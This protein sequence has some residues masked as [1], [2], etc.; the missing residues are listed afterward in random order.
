[1][2]L[3]RLFVG[4]LLLW[5]V[6]CDSPSEPQTGP[7][8][9]LDLLSGN[10]QEATV[11]QPL[12]DPLV[13]R[14]FDENGT[15]LSSQLLNF[16]VISG[17]GSVFAGASLTNSDGVAQE[18]WTLGTSA[19]TQR[20]EV[21]A[22]DNA[23]GE[24]LVFATFVAVAKAGA[25]AAI[26]PVG[27][28]TVT[29][30]AGDAVTDSLVARVTDQYG[31]PVPNIAV[32]WSVTAGSGAVSSA[33]TNTD[34][35]GVARVQWTLGPRV[36]TTQIVTASVM[37]STLATSY[38]ANVTLPANIVVTK[39]SGD[40]QTG[41]VATELMQPLVVSVALADGR[42]VV[43]AG[44]SWSSQVGAVTPQ[45]HTTGADGRA[46]ARWTL[47]TVAGNQTAAASVQGSAPAQFQAL[48]NPAAPAHLIKVS[49][50]AQS[51]NV[52]NALAQPL[53][54]RVRDTY[55]NAVPNALVYWTVVTGNG[56][57]APDSARADANGDSRTVW[58]LGSTSGQ[59]MAR[60]EVAGVA[61]VTFTST[62]HAPIAF[63]VLAP[64]SGSRVSDTVSIAAQTSS[65]LEV[66]S[67]VANVGDRQTNLTFSNGAWRGQIVLT[68]LPRGNYDLLLRATDAAGHSAT[69]D[70]A[71]ILD[72]RPRLT[73][74]LPIN[75]SVARP[76]TRVLASCTDDDPTPC[77]IYIGSAHALCAFTGTS[78]SST[79]IGRGVGTVDLQVSL[80]AWEGQQRTLVIRAADS[81]SQTAHLLQ[82]V[83]VESSSRWTEVASAGIHLFDYD[84]TRL[85]YRDSSA[86]GYS[87]QIRNLQSGITESISDSDKSTAFLTPFGAIFE[88]GNN[89]FERRN[90]SLLDLGSGNELEVAGAWA[91]WHSATASPVQLLRRDLMAGLTEPVASNAGNTNNDVAANGDVVYWDPTYDI[92]RYRSGVTNQLT[93]DNDAVLWNTYPI[94]DGTI[95]VYRKSTP[96][97]TNQTYRLALHDGTTELLLTA[98]RSMQPVPDL[99]YA[100]SEG[101]VAFTDLGP[102]GSL[103]VFSRAPDGTIRQVSQFSSESRVVS[104]GRAGQVIFRNNGRRYLSLPPYANQPVDIG[105]NWGTII[106]I[107]DQPYVLLG[108]SLFRID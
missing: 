37:A 21:R 52:S 19:D 62:A 78:C 39:T 98:F 17:N 60:A 5:S 71:F 47:G 68:G 84:G 63:T 26:A 74:T 35:A 55:G 89:I 23:T 11:G 65:H 46:S 8:A 29:G 93:S 38:Q 22:V 97:C 49:G 2:K 80:A 101:W 87:V 6:S 67:V 31:N 85:L 44:V 70:H 7:A 40:A 58:T 9:R 73:V 95:L 51:A 50:D 91:M 77:E 96:C 48:A 82:L 1:M 45:T 54:A 41:G 100:V 36:D 99:D 106:W 3:A 81:A 18:R 34:I 92:H 10:H 24:P 64:A 43:G 102:G 12:G 108:R 103:Q 15:P 59:G 57:V 32:V 79:E 66:Q 83:A 72:R 20:V 90:G 104:V 76:T 75:G 105:G 69:Y 86:A 14:V 56:S 28:S 33:T 107:G 94:T 30:A 27:N 4:L 88:D 42:P 13:V 53:T 16:R 25:P 61:P